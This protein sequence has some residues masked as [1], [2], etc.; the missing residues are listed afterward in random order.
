MFNLIGK[1]IITI[2]V[3]VFS[4]GGAQAMDKSQ[5]KRVSDLLNILNSGLVTSKCVR[6]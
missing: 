1:S 4:I 6:I 2:A 3:L 5:L